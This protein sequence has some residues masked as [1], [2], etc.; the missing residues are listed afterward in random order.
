MWA[1]VGVLLGLVVVASVL[2]F[3]VG[4]HGHIVGA[5]LGIAAA[6]WLIVMA[7]TGQSAPL[8]WILLG[9][10]VALSGGLAAI[11][12]RGLRSAEL[13]V[14]PA[15]PGLVGSEGVAVTDLEPGGVVRVRGENW[16]ATS[17]NGSVKAGDRVQVIEASGVRLSVWAEESAVEPD[18]E[19]HHHLLSGHR[20]HHGAGDP[21]HEG[22]Q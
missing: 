2:G 20:H 4:P 9:A 10:D 21:E 6:I 1:G 15:T 12:W 13:H 11:A 19:E 5:G 8:L 7:A 14:G 3:H 17:M 18:P 16:S 22:E